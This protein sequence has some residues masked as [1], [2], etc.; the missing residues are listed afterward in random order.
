MML[1][2]Y[3]HAR[4]TYTVTGGSL[5]TDAAALSDRSPASATR[6]TWPTGT[7]TTATTCTITAGFTEQAVRTVAL[8]GTSLPV[9]LKV[10]LRGKR[11]GDADYTYSLGAASLTQTLVSRIDGGTGAVWVLP[12]GN[13]A[14]IGL[15]IRL[16]NDVGGFT[17][18]SAGD[19]FDTGEIVISDG[20]EFYINAE[21]TLGG[22]D[23]SASRR[24]LG[25]QVSRVGRP[26]YRILEFS[27]ALDSDDSVLF[28]GLSNGAAWQ[29]LARDIR[30][31]PYVLAIASTKTADYI[32]AT[33]VYGEVTKIPDF[34]H[35]AGPY[36]EPNQTTVEEIPAL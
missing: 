12:Q 1:L 33:S 9:G 27:P 25:S 18:L 36:Y 28:G 20:A 29:E 31:D 16:Y 8:L 10:E 2:A 21:W 7:Q 19:S 23:P 6:I 32:Q 17:S 13:D 22:K 30:D 11:S 35:K 34:L 4:P 15:Q 5:V 26:G 14:L 3:N 24:T